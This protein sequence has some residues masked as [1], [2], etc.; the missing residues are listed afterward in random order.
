MLS[1]APESYADGM[2]LPRALARFN[3]RVTNPIQRRW[4]GKIPAHGIVEHRGRSSGRAYRTPVLAFRRPGGFVMM[5]G[6]GLHSDWVRN[7]C[8]AGTGAVV[9]RGFK[10]VLSEPRVLTGGS[11]WPA[12]PGPVGWAA[13]LLRVD[14]V[15]VADAGEPRPRSEAATGL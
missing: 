1:D 9:H 3:R 10:Y 6:Y 13:R 11:A 8:A 5:I 14:G 2:H 4:A 12:L 7:L 15:L